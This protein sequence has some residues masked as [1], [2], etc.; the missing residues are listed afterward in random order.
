MKRIWFKYLLL[1]FFTQNTFGQIGADSNSVP[2]SIPTISEYKPKTKKPIFDL[3]RPTIGI[4]SGLFSYYGDVLGNNIQFPFTSRVGYELF[5]NYRLTRSLLFDF[6]VLFG[7]LGAN[8]RLGIRN[9][10]FL[11]EI[12]LGGLRFN[13]DFSNLLKEKAI[14]KPFI[15][16]GIE[17]FEFLSKTDLFDK[18]SN[19]YFYWSDGSIRNAPEGSGS[20]ATAQIIKRDYIY[21]SDIREL[22][23]DKFGKYLERSFAIPAG[24]GFSM[25]IGNRTRLKFASTM[26]FTFTD[27]I[28]G[29]TDKSLG[30]RIGRKG[31]DNFM[32]NSVSLHYDLAIDKQLEALKDPFISD[33]EL[34]VLDNGD[35]DGDGVID[36][37]DS[38]HGTPKGVKVD[39]KGCPMDD[40][41]DN[42]FNYR[43]RELETKAGAP[44]DSIG[45]TIGDSAFLRWYEKYS[46]TNDIKFKLVDLDTATERTK[47]VLN[48][49]KPRKK[50]YT[51]QINNYKNGIPTGELT[52]LLG[53]PDLK[54]FNNP[55]DTSVSVT[56]GNFATP[57][58]A[59]AAAEKLKKEGFKDAKAGS[60][61]FGDGRFNKELTAAEL[62]E[63]IKKQDRIG[64]TKTNK[65]NTQSFIDTNIIVF[66]VQLGAYKKQLSTTFFKN[67]GNVV[68][69]VTE[70]GLYKYLSGSYSTL[71]DAATYRADM[72]LEG[73][74]D[75]F[76]AA[77]K[78]GRR[79]PLR[80]AGAIPSQDSTTQ[81]KE[82]LNENINTGSALDRS[83]ISFRVQLGIFKNETIGDATMANNGV[84]SIQKSSTVGGLV[85]FTSGNFANYPEAVKYKN[86]LA[87]KGFPDAF[88]VAFFKNEAIPLTEALE[89]LKQ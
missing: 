28:D 29:I 58:E 86:D 55:E 14:I 73:Y 56:V 40:D 89:L 52:K 25:E 41:K 76:I 77:Y 47:F 32:M 6:Y 31:M 79:I 2:Q 45:V 64:N 44:V 72:V 39:A 70:D 85:R 16:T 69:V 11:S 4:G 27:L 71:V 60:S 82:E 9:E 46:D 35:A 67:T 17:S 42:V 87:T 81:I 22:N 88:V 18:N 7:K 62:A 19:A 26:H 3:S 8:E 80:A 83:E 74:T 51:V 12:R 78:A 13:Y 1:L 59:K 36:D 15:F 63:A 33:D 30:N 37:L 75:A 66:R 84:Q 50:S 5:I 68:G 43:D 53:I 54:T 21:E 38:C 57:E 48:G 49:F 34:Y 61:E 10:N 65:K 23:K 20:S 24:V